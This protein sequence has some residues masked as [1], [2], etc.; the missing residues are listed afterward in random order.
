M[1]ASRVA[2]ANSLKALARGL[3]PRSTW[4]AAG[5]LSVAAWA[6]PLAAAVC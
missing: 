3:S 2:L 4:E 5:A 6:L 1:T